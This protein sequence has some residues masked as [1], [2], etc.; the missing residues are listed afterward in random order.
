VKRLYWR[1]LFDDH[2]L[3]DITELDVVAWLQGKIQRLKHADEPEESAIPH[4]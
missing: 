1:G 4:S 3:V 2:E